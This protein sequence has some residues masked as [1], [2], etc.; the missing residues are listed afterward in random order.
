MV[1]L[2]TPPHI[3][4]SYLVASVIKVLIHGKQGLQQDDLQ[5]SSWV[6]RLLVWDS[7][8]NIIQTV[9]GLGTITMVVL[10]C[11]VRW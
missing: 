10:F 2:G 4:L 3:T 7:V 11:L 8:V 5:L 9:V 1:S 6:I